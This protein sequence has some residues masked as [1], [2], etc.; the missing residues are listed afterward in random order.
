MCQE[1]HLK[2]LGFKSEKHQGGKE[3]LFLGTNHFLRTSVHV[4]QG[5][6]LTGFEGASIEVEGLLLGFHL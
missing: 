4:L 3:I 1:A 5:F 2:E 6:S